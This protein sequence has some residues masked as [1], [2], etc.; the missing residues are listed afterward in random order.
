MA[1]SPN[2]RF[3]VVEAP[4]NAPG[5]CHICK[6]TSRGPF[7]DTQVNDPWNGHVTYLCVGCLSDIFNGLPE[8]FSN[9]ETIT[10]KET[11]EELEERVKAEVLS[12]IKD[13]V[14]ELVPGE[15]DSV[16]VIVSDLDSGP[17]PDSENVP[18]LPPGEE[19]DGTSADRT[20]KQTSRAAK[21][22]G[23]VGVSSDPVDGL[24]FEGFELTKS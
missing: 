19:G 12:R 9:V 10:V 21:R 5:A 15:P 7:V 22:E 24:S 11:D 6:S 13:F 4:T 14:N 2:D 18:G 3:Q 16:P 17:V 8:F 23:P 20:A 1:F